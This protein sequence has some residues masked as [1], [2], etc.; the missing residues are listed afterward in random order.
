MHHRGDQDHPS[1]FPVLS[2]H[3]LDHPSTLHFLPTTSP[4]YILLPVLWIQAL[5]YFGSSKFFPLAFPSQM[6]LLKPRTL[7]VHVPLPSLGR[8]LSCMMGGYDSGGNH[9]FRK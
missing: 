5:L 4:S 9:S 1:H 2:A 7:S 8:I 3:T 6:V